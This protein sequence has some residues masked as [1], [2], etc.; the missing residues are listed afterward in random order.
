MH[1]TNTT[2]SSTP[3]ITL[4]LGSG[5][6]RGFCFIGALAA[7]EEANVPIKRIIGVSMGSIVGG[8]FALG[9]T[10]S[11]L[12]EIARRARPGGLP[13]FSL[14]GPG[15][16][17]TRAVRKLVENFVP[18]PAVF[19]D[20]KIPLSV[21][22]TNY[23][24]GCPIE[25]N[26]GDLQSAVLG[27]SVAGAIF[28]PVERGETFLIDGG[29]SAPVPVQFTHPGEIVV[30]VSAMV[31]PEADPGAKM[32]LR[33]RNLMPGWL[34]SKEMIRMFDIQGY[35]LSE[36]QLRGRDH[37]GVHPEL[38]SLKFTDFRRHAFA[39][40]CGYEAMVDKI[41]NVQSQLGLVHG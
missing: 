19:E 18:K 40:A 32:G 3:G 4:V 38:G 35:S 41:P 13:T 9:K 17:T 30:A 29:Y 37:I 20:L 39:I 12:K 25:I 7:L 33:F 26:S 11:E 36:A 27:S 23:R 16:F 15:L 8:A 21:I 22:C 6:A 1:E 31:D 2:S 10:S 24:T 14:A 5:G 28:S 34:L